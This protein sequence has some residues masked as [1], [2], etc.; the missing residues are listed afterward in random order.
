MARP[1][2]RTT[3]LRLRLRLRLHLQL[4][5]SRFSDTKMRNEVR[6]IQDLDAIFRTNYEID[7]FLG[8]QS[9]GTPKGILFRYPGRCDG[10][11]FFRRRRRASPRVSCLVSFYIRVRYSYGESKIRNYNN[12]VRSV[13]RAPSRYVYTYIIVWFFCEQRSNGRPTISWAS[14]RTNFARTRGSWTRSPVPKTWS[15]CWTRRRR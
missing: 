13:I 6:W 1:S 12:Y 11:S 3:R 4:G 5:T 8:W 15:C 2:L 14:R 9:F 10:S 7:P